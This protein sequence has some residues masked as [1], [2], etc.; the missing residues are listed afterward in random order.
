MA[1]SDASENDLFAAS[2]E[3]ASP[4]TT[5][6]SIQN[7]GVTQERGSRALPNP[8]PTLEYPA[9]D[10]QKQLTVQLKCLIKPPIGGIVRH[11]K[12]NPWT[13]IGMSRA[14]WYRH[15]KPTKKP[16]KQTLAQWCAEHGAKLRTIQR[17]KRVFKDPELREAVDRGELTAH[18]AE[19]YLIREAKRLP[20]P[21][22]LLP[23][24]S[25]K[26]V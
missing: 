10:P 25:D 24:E 21:V 22:I 6:K 4:D 1:H 17:Y 2:A 18:A 26:P 11:M 7:H 14:S 12:Q 3:T 19:Q 15:G 20:H 16:V 5:R 8:L 9:G 13:A 23:D